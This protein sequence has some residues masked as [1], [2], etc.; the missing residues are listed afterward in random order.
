MSWRR[1]HNIYEMSILRHIK[2]SDINSVIELLQVR[3][4]LQ[5]GA[6]SRR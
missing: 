1:V 6:V 3:D 5:F 2:A 4:V